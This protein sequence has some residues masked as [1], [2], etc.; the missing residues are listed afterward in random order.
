MKSFSQILSHLGGKLLGG[1]NFPGMLGS[2]K[3]SHKNRKPNL[4]RR[5]H[6]PLMGGWAHKMEPIGQVP[7]VSV[8]GLRACEI[9]TGMDLMVDHRG[10]C[11]RRHYN[12]INRH[13]E[14]MDNGV[15]RVAGEV[16]STATTVTEIVRDIM[17]AQ[18]KAGY[19]V[20]PAESLRVDLMKKY[21]IPFSTDWGSVE[22][23]KFTSAIA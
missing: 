15:N 19:L 6:K 17:K 5:M 3:M 20:E 16:I 12:R 9:I 4:F 22:L 8:D 14:F 7:A 18:D 2:S 13:G 23:V 21:S 1:L 10:V 11:Y